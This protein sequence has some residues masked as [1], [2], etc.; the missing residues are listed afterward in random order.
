MKN[1]L[2][3][4]AAELNKNSKNR[5]LWQRFVRFLAVAVVFCT[6]YI[7]ILPAITMEGDPVCGY[8][9]H[10]HDE[11]CYEYTWSSVME[12]N[13]A[14][15][16]IVVHVHDELCFDLSGNLTC[17]LEEK[18]EHTHDEYCYEE[19]VIC[20][21]AEDENHTHTEE[22]YEKV[23]VC[24]V[25]EVVLHEHE[26]GCFDAESVLIC[27]KPLVISHQ[28]DESCLVVTEYST[29]ICE[30][31]EHIH[32]ELC[33]MEEDP[34]PEFICGMG[35]HAHNE[36]CFDEYGNQLCTIPVHA[37]DETCTGKVPEEEE[38]K[39]VTAAAELMAN[40]P[41]AEEVQAK[42]AA[43]NNSFDKESYE[44]YLEETKALV[45]FA[46][47]AFAA[48]DDAQKALAG[49]IAP[50]NELET[51]LGSVVWQDARVLDKDDA[52]VSVLGAGETETTEVKI[53]ETAF[54]PFHAEIK[55]ISEENYGEARVKLEFVLPLKAEQA[56]FD[57]EAMPWLED[58]VLTAENRL[59]GEA[60]T[61]C[62]VLTGYKR[63][64]AET[65]D[66]FVV[67]GSFEESVA[68]KVLEMNN[69]DKISVKI[70][71]AMEYGTWNGVCPEH[72]AE[73]K[74]TV[75]S[76]TFTVS[77][78]ASAEEQQA[79]YEALIAEYEAIGANEELGEEEK[80]AAY[81][82]LQTAAA[83]KYKSGR[84][85]EE[86][87]ADLSEKFTIAIY[88]SL[89]T[90]A[91]VAIGDNWKILAESG[92]FEEYSNYEEMY[93]ESTAFTVYNSATISAL[94]AAPVANAVQY[95]D[96]QIIEQGGENVSDEAAVMVSKTIAGT[97]T[98]NVFDITL[99]II[100]QDVV[101]EV[102]KE[103]DMAVV[104]VMDI[105]QTMNTAFGSSTR[106]KSAMTAAEN[107]IDQFRANN[108]GAS[109]IGFVSFNTNSQQ[110][111]A[112][113]QCYTTAQAASLK[114]TMRTKTGEIINASD[115]ASAHSRFTN[116]ESG[117]KRAKDM[118]A[119]VD[120]E[121]KYI[122][123]LSDG[124]PTTYISSGYN[125][126]DP[127]DSSGSRF[128][129]SVQ[130]LNNKNRPCTYGTSYSDEAA[131]R[132]R[133]MA[134][135]I[136]DSGTTI[137]SIGVD[138]GT[139]TIKKYVDQCLETTHSV[140]DRRNTNYEIGS[141]T[142]ANAFKRWLGN[143][144]GSGY[145]GYYFDSTNTTGLTNAFNNIFEKILEINAESSHLDWVATDPMGDMGVH[146][147]DSV[148]FIGFFDKDG[149]LVGNSLSGESGDGAQYEN[150][151][152]FNTSTSTIEW[153]IKQSGYVS[154]TF[155]NTTNYWCTLTYRIRLKNEENL[156]AEHTEYF[157]NDVTS[158]T[159]RVIEQTGSNVSVS[160]RRTVEFPI[161]SVE[162]YLGELTFDKKDVYGRPV[163]GAEFTLTHDTS[164]CGY[165]RGD[166]KGHVTIA[167]VTVT[168]GENGKVSF[169]NIPSG[170]SYVLAETKVPE[171]YKANDNIYKVTV[172]YD[173][174]TVTVTDKDGNPVTWEDV[175]FN[176]T[177]YKL[178]E[179]GGSGANPV[180]IGGI[181]IISVCIYYVIH[182][183]RKF[184]KG[185]ACGK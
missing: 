58:A 31:E 139:Q 97:E 103:P 144:I 155:G 118:L 41:A 9:E 91:E 1:V 54:F 117:L 112:L 21:L 95:S 86:G 184:R 138:V 183:E 137:F 125:G 156:F 42:L 90:V 92:W 176:Y 24:K 52:I 94:A 148:E 158:L 53:G 177:A 78:V 162:G 35:V 180:T 102:Y 143:S 81:E 151:A 84:L 108:K 93:A 61:E 134:A 82:A 165:C 57:T 71:A 17:L 146:D 105:S 33:Y 64:K 87:F 96:Q 175:I 169:T 72:N 75:V 70:S 7:L 141:A 174:L 133:K 114:N 171:G 51:V 22:C 89:D 25:E 163:A 157:T 65:L 48:L 99:D 8:E 38:D 67:P 39:A 10:T 181:M 46:K 101:T 136:K 47:E 98:E 170:H 147:M 80:R 56:A 142:D 110:I 36:K 28:H 160:E 20:E 153:D 40:L 182:V 32:N 18:A 100:T 113:Q 73:E 119:A 30:A 164:S 179:T 37:H 149:T 59:F 44:A 66:K 152:S 50:V 49:D 145:N 128:Y 85:S 129:D 63:L 123:F 154:T 27:E 43:F 6:T 68:V 109:K 11:N 173:E 115:Y 130:K 76:Q 127:Y 131:I 74:L 15:E 126:Y 62:Q 14:E 69:G 159:Y 166:G 132:A 5:R 161:P 79:E 55:S 107:F 34:E 106:Y 116:I 124:F 16:A 121:H 23:F 88:G 122:V 178:P 167:P 83:E 45:S 140:V 12:C 111:F 2:L 60:E 120:N 185:G 172:A 26:E 4:K 168:S 104:I 3:Q 13:I 135:T 77:A 150:T 19:Q 29:F